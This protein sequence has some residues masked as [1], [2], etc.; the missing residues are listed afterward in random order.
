MGLPIERLRVG[1]ERE[2]AAQLAERPEAR[3]LDPAAL[4]RRLDP[5]WNRS[6]SVYVPP[7]RAPWLH[8]ALAEARAALD[9][10]REVDLFLAQDET[11]NAHVVVPPE[12]SEPIAIRVTLGAV[13]RW[14]A[15]ELLAVFGH[16]LGHALAHQ[17]DDYRRA[18]RLAFDDDVSPSTRALAERHLLACE[19]TAD[20]FALLACRDPSVALATQRTAGS[21]E[22]VDPPRVLEEARAAVEDVEALAAPPAPAALRARAQ[23]L[24]AESALYRELGGPG[25]GTLEEAE[26]EARVARLLTL[27]ADGVD[28]ERRPV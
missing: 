16:E 15:A 17:G 4:H 9:V 21:E 7:D 25:P 18:R 11:A 23:W 5:F 2:L 13:R 22:S 28:A 27:P 14:G 20:R 24:F 3:D 12:A 19:M 10:T 1:A 8:R 6:T 26:L